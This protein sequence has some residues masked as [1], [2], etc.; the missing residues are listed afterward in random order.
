MIPER[1]KNAS[2]ECFNLYEIKPVIEWMKSDLHD[3]LLITGASGCGK[4]HLMMAICKE[5][6]KR[7]IKT[8]Y[9]LFPEI[10]LELR[11]AIGSANYDEMAVIKKYRNPSLVGCFDDLGANK[12]SDYVTESLYAIINHRYQECIPSVYSSNLG[13]Q[14]IADLY[15]DRIAS[16]L[17][18]GV[19]FNMG[20]KDKRLEK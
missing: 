7:C 16:R 13:L 4:T 6:N 5:L 17:A 10:A 18:S 15:G 2:I 3:V 9:V 20:D 19:V 8:A 14:K 1:Y 11:Q 12:P